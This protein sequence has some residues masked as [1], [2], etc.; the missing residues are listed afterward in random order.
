MMASPAGRFPPRSPSEFRSLP[1]CGHDCF[2][3]EDSC[4]DTQTLGRVLNA[5]KTAR[6]VMTAAGKYPYMAIVQMDC[7]PVPVPF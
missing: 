2:T 7:D 3:V 6:P 4:A 5:G 1:K